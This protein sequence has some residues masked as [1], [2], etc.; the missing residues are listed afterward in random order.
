MTGQLCNK[1]GTI[2]FLFDWIPVLASWIPGEV[3]VCIFAAMLAWFLNRSMRTY[4]A[5][6]NLLNMPSVLDLMITH[7]H[8]H[9]ESMDTVD[10]YRKDFERR[11]IYPALNAIEYFSV[12]VNTKQMFIFSYFSF[13][14][15]RLSA[16]Q[17]FVSLWNDPDVKRFVDE[18]RAISGLHKTTYNELELLAKRL[19]KKSGLGPDGRAKG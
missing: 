17:M 6:T 4:S 11:V 7:D 5:L 10:E 15:V 19:R 14:I 18:E 13:R 12:M 9:Y 3:V 8:S 2:S 16:G 1:Q